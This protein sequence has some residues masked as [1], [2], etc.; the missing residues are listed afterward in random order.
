MLETPSNQTHHSRTTLA[1]SDSLFNDFTNTFFSTESER[2]TFQHLKTIDD[3]SNSKYRHRYSGAKVVINVRP[4]RMFSMSSLTSTSIFSSW[5]TGNEPLLYKVSILC[6]NV[7]MVVIQSPIRIQS[8]IPFDITNQTPN[9]NQLPICKSPNK[10]IP[11]P[12]PTFKHLT[13]THKPTNG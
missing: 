12:K 8:S 9:L 5:S 11:N 6:H 2:K 3:P 10:S 1:K 4:F 13:N 7:W